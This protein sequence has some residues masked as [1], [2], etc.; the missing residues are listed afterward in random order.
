MI[1]GLP[2]MI[3]AAVE[4]KQRREAN[5]RAARH[6]RDEEIREKKHAA[7]RRVENPAAVERKHIERVCFWTWPFGHAWRLDSVRHSCG[8]AHLRCVGCGKEQPEGCQP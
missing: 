8:R 5:E 3:G 2:Q 4:E 7:R 1:F 6:A